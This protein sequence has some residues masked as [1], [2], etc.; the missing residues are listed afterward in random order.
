MR[1]RLFPD[2][3]NLSATAQRHPPAVWHELIGRSERAACLLR[4]VA[5]VLS[6]PGMAELIPVRRSDIVIMDNQRVLHRRA[7][8]APRWDGTDRYFIRV[9][10]VRDP[11]AGIPADPRR[12]WIW[13]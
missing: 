5:A 1:R 10:A 4:E 13:S 6:D 9:S 3:V 8:F 11:R 12:P 2:P 7:S